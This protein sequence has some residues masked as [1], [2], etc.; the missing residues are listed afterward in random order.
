MVDRLLLGIGYLDVPDAHREA[1]V[2]A[3][4]LGDHFKEQIIRA[5]YGGPLRFPKM[6]LAI[7]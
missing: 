7:R 2:K 1:V 4:P 6:L 3:H 5:F